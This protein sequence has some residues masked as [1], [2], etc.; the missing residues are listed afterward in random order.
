[1]NPII[2]DPFSLA[3]QTEAVLLDT[4]R[5]DQENKRSLLFVSPR[6]HL[7]AYDPVEVIPVLRQ[8][9]RL[10]KTCWLAGYLRYEAVYGLL[11]K[12]FTP[13]ELRTGPRRPLVWFGVYDALSVVTVKTPSAYTPR[14]TTSLNFPYARYAQAIARIK[15]EIRAGNSYQVN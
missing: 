9:D 10:S 3:G 5:A 4:A 6:T 14:I 1:M 13:P 2:F 8:M 12:K 7:V 11:P 15:D